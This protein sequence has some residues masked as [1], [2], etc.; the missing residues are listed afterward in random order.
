MLLQLGIAVAG[1]VALGAAS[2]VLV[3]L[4]VGI[5]DAAAGIVLADLVIFAGDFGKPVGGLDGVERPIDVNLLELIDQDDRRSRK[6]GM[7]RAETVRFSRL[8]GP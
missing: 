4:L 6:I 3:E 7:L 8:L 1:I 5:I 2:V